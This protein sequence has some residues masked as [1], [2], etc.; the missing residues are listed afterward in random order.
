LEGNFQVHDDLKRALQIAE[1]AGRELHQRFRTKIT[2]SIKA[3]DSLVTEADLASQEVVCRELARYFPGDLLL[4]EEGEQAFDFSP[5]NRNVWIVDPLDGTSNFA[6][7]YDY[8]CV[9]I[10]RARWSEGRWQPDLG[11]IHVPTQRRSYCAA[12]SLGAWVDGR[13]L[14]RIDQSDN[15]AFSRRFLVTG[16]AYDQGQALEQSV[17][18]FLKVASHC[19]SIRR[20]GAAALDL[21]HVAEG[22]FD[23]YW[24]TGVKPWDVAAGLVILR[25][26][27]ARCCDFSGA[28]FDLRRPDLVVGRPEVVDTLVNLF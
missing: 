15:I 7:G 22:V 8:F 3:D 24:E 1:L 21:A 19:N 20:P 4:A 14:G 16:F 2:S 28:E 11:V 9:S 6:R 23:A 17:A 5:S 18:R 10:A 26:L 12:L 13:R 25:E 27:G